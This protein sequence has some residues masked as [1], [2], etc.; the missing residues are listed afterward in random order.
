[1]NGVMTS[2]WPIKSSRWFYL[3]TCGLGCSY[4]FSIFTFNV[5]CKGH[6]RAFKLESQYDVKPV[7][8]YPRSQ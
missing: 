5:H 3:Y 7:A 4:L 1:M 8:L 2:L 6:K